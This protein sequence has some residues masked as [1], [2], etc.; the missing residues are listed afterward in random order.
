MPSHQ[1]TSEKQAAF[2][3]RT[4]YVST[5]ES[6]DEQ[7]SKKQSSAVESANDQTYDKPM[8]KYEFLK[9]WGGRENFQASY[10][11]KMTPDDIDEGN[12]II[13]AMMAR[14]EGRK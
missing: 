2:I 3:A 9:P 13:E 5:H 4:G 1:K 7:M 6:T 8:S 12:A 10:G 14:H 11:L